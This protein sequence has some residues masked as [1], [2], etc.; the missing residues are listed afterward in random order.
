MQP[1]RPSA[2]LYMRNLDGE[3]DADG[4]VRGFFAQARGVKTS[5][6]TME[7][8]IG[9]DGRLERVLLFDDAADPYQLHNLAP[10][11]NP[12]L[13]ASLC[14]ELAVLLRDNDDVWF[15]ERVLADV[16]P[17]DTSN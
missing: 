12:E 9:R 7:L 8:R 13:F 17:Y 2:A 1:R 14:R 15:R 16:V 5:T 6:H 10:E 11:E 4:M 3:R